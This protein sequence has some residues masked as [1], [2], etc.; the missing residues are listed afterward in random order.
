M[1]SIEP[2]WYR[3]PAAPETQRYWDGE[4]WIGA[5]LP[6]DAPAPDGPPAP[7]PEPVPVP[8]TATSTSANSEPDPSWAPPR[9][10]VTPIDRRPPTGYQPG[11]GPAARPGTPFGMPET[12]MRG[13]VLATPGQ[14]LV[15]RLIDIVA[16]LLLIAVVDGYFI[17]QFMQ[18]VWPQVEAAALN[19]ETTY[20]L[21]LSER[22]GQ[23]QMTIILVALLLWYVYEVPMTTYT[24][25][26]LGKRMVGIKVVPVYG[27]PMRIFPNSLRWSFMALPFLILICGWIILVADALWCLRDKPLR[28]CLHD[29]SPGTAVILAGSIPTQGDPDGQPDPR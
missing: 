8:G 12:K 9:P 2:G 3:D 24:G 1:S 5:A 23:L 22:A 20:P 6:A 21:K 19:G 10:D 14:R 4:Q 7:E 29:K 28:Q 18:E 16:I 11:A 26:T 17:F 25:Q 13:V 15:A 27:Q